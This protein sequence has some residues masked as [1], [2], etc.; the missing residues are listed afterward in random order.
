MRYALELE[1]VAVPA[2]STRSF[3]VNNGVLHPTQTYSCLPL[4]DPIEVKNSALIF[5]L[6]EGESGTPLVN[7]LCKSSELN[8]KLE[9]DAIEGTYTFTSLPLTLTVAE[10]FT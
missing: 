3:V 7:F 8:C 5:F 1:V 6:I 9:P 2:F 4:L 10:P